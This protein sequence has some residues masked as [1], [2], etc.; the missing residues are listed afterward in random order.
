MILEVRKGLN[1]NSKVINVYQVNGEN[2][3]RWSHDTAAHALKTAGDHV[4]LK[5]IYK[6]KGKSILII[7]N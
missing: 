4:T 2:L 3:E 5:V 7:I 6:P 1:I